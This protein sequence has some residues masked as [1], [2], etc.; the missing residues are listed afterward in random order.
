[1]ILQKSYSRYHLTIPAELV[2][3]LGWEKGKELGVFPG[4]NKHEILIRELP[5]KR[6]KQNSSC[7]YLSKD[8]M[9][10]EA[11]EKAY[12]NSGVNR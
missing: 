2:K 5:E 9:S 3:F 1:M 4:S 6:N 11:G 7:I 8:S 12:E 10:N